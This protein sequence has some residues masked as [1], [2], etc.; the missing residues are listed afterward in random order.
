MAKVY[1]VKNGKK[2]GIFNTWA[3]CEEQVK[4]F[5]GAQFKS[6]PT[7]DEAKAY[8]GIVSNTI[9]STPSNTN[10]DQIIVYVDGS[11]NPATNECGYAAYLLHNQKIKVLYGSFPMQD[12][13]RNVEG[14]VKAATEAINYLTKKPYKD[15]VIYYDYEGVCKWA[16]KLWKTN[17][18]YTR[19][20]AEYVNS[21]RNNLN[22]KIKYSHVES[23]TGVEGNEIVDKLAKYACK[24]EM[25]K[26]DQALVEEILSKSI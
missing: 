3:E 4:G 15:I 2:V 17:R 5:S 26:K 1:A 21:V 19:K 10:S 24:V 25:P 6:F 13:G 18:E 20:Y 23:H 14:E 7:I 22:M 16:D 11:F 9:V 12:G 8:L